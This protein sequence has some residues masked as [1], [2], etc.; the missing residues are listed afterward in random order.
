MNVALQAAFVSGGCVLVA[1]L[2]S[3]VLPKLW[4]QG[5]AIHEVRE[6]VSNSHGSNLRDDLDLVRDLVLDVREGLKDLRTDM[7]WERRERA[8]MT[9]RIERL[10]GP[11]L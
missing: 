6:Q 5:R 1:T 4:K 11:P 3:V 9:K 2:I 10:E 7:A 8:D